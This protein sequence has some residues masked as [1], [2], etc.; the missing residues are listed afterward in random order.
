MTTPGFSDRFVGG[1]VSLRDVL[2]DAE[3]RLA[4]AGVPS[5]RTDA[6]ILA[7]FVT[8]VPRTR[9]LLHDEITQEQRTTYERLLSRRMARVPL[10]H[11]LGQT[12]FRHLDLA[13]GPG[14]FVPRPE[15]ELVAEAAIAALAALP[16]DRRVAVDLCSGSGAIALAVATEVT[17]ARVLAV[18]MDPAAAEWAQRNIEIHEPAVADQGS[19]IS[20][21]KGDARTVAGPTGMLAELREG[22]DVVVTNPPYIPEDATPTEPEVRDH[23]PHIALF[24]GP[25]GLDVI[26]DLLTTAALLLRPG[27]V[28]VIEHADRQGEA[29]GAG[30]VPALLREHDT[31]ECWSAVTDHLDLTRRPRFTTAVRTAAMNPR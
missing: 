16:P 2:T 31:A 23:E 26:R 15:T 4:A 7:S 5:P 21:L 22:V 3:R 24:G 25:D 27:G 29:A 1:W 11:L 17:G 30:G 28:L 8:G 19:Q 18:E 13:V 20:L 12:T 9:M 14:V 10:Q 6:A